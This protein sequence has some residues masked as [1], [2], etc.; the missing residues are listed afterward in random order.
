MGRGAKGYVIEPLEETSRTINNL[1]GH[2]TLTEKNLIAFNKIQIQVGKEE[3][4]VHV[5]DYG[6]NDS[7]TSRRVSDWVKQRV[8]QIPSVEGQCVKDEKEFNLSDNVE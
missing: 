8:V 3:E 4:A 1:Q 7:G 2:F 5:D 6:Y